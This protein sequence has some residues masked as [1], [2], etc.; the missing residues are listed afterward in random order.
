MDVTKHDLADLF[1]G[2]LVYVVPNYQRLYV[3]NREDQWEPLWLD[4]AEVANTLLGRALEKNVNEVDPNSAEPHFMGAVVLKIGGSTPNMARQRRV[5]DGQQRL[6]TLQLMVTAAA[7]ALAEL[8][9]VDPADRLRELVEN[10]SRSTSPNSH[11]YKIS[12]Y[13][14]K[15]GGDY[16]SFGKV[17]A[18]ALGGDD[19]TN[20]KG[21]MGDCYRF[22][23][24]RI[25][26]VAPRS[27]YTCSCGWFCNRYRTAHEAPGGWNLSRLP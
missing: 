15:P 3:W 17:I 24:E 14:H 1:E 26:G 5:I 19:T 25:I 21:P 8:G 10:R 27:G 9:L 7:A 6:T 4:T 20:I 11:S 16:E 12:H 23:Y 18:A 22:F 13:R 2:R